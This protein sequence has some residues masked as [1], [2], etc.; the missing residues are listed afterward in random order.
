MSAIPL[1][2][3][4]LTCACLAATLLALAPAASARRVDRRS[5]SA[6]LPKVFPVGKVKARERV[7]RIVAT[8]AAGAQLEAMVQVYCFDEDVKVH[9]RQKTLSGTGTIDARI[10]RPRGKGLD[11]SA[12][13]DVRVAS[14]PAPP[15]DEPI[16]PIRLTVTLSAKR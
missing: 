13:A 3:L 4:A 11:C 9:R 6:V 16:A 2:R 5:A 8:S 12:S 10:R 7:V 14:R 1:A 15:N